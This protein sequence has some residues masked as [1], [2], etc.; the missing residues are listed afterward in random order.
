M[1]ITK[2]IDKYLNEVKLNKTETE[3]MNMLKKNKR[4]RDGR[5]RKWIPNT[6]RYF[7]AAKSLEK[8][9]LVDFDDQSS[10]KRTDYRDLFGGI[11]GKYY[12]DYAGYII[13]KED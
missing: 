11:G 1:N 5:L 7:N 8:K 13:L 4:S 2:K 12:T 3:L 6:K 9:G 10:R